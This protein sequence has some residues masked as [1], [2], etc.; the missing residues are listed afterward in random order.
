[1][2]MWILQ[3][4]STEFNNSENKK[5]RWII[6]RSLSN[7]HYVIKRLS[8]QINIKRKQ[9]LGQIQNLNS[10][11][12][13][14]GFCFNESWLHFNSDNPKICIRISSR[15]CMSTTVKQGDE[16][17]KV[18]CITPKTFDF[19]GLWVIIRYNNEAFLEVSYKTENIRTFITG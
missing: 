11:S 16:S 15:K 4:L 5:M 8:L 13:M 6:I 9:V 1:M 17:V 10:K 18:T 3:K 7:A 14:R 19:Q 2:K 12:M